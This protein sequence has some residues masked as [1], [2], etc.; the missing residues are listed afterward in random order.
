MQVHPTATSVGLA[1]AAAVMLSVGLLQQNPPIVGWGCAMMIGI[2]LARAAT[3]VSVSR[4]RAA[5]LELVWKEP[6]KVLRLTRGQRE[7]LT[8]E[9]RN[10]D[11]RAT[12]FVGLRCVA[13]DGLLI[14]TSP[15]QGQVPA[16][17]RLTVH[18]EVLAARVG[19]HAVQTLSFEVSAGTRLFEVP[20]TFASPI[21]VEVLPSPNPQQL[22]PPRGAFVRDGGPTTTRR[23]G[24]GTELRELRQYLPGD[25]LKHVAWKSSA[26]RG[27]LMVR[28]YEQ[29][30]LDRILLVLD[31][32]VELWAGTVGSAPLDRAIDA[33]A[34]VAL[35]HLS[36]G[37]EVG[38]AIVGPVRPARVRPA[39]GAAQAKQLLETLA[40]HSGCFDEPRSTF[41]LEELV[42]RVADHLRLVDSALG[43]RLT[44]PGP[45]ELA[46]LAAAAL[47][48]APISVPTPWAPT[49]AE[50]VLRRYA[51]AF[52]LGSPPRAEGDRVNTDRQL[53]E[54]LE[55]SCHG[56]GKPSLVYVWS[57]AP[58]P[59][60][61]PELER[62]LR[63]WPRRG[64]ALTWM[65]L[66][67]RPEAIPGGPE[68]A[69]VETAVSARVAIREAQAQRHLRELGV[70]VHQRKSLG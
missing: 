30:R 2:G 40:H 14:E 18:V 58:S 8:A 48:R 53:V 44:S 39:T 54:V 12:L 51:A 5:G 50:A 33:V 59:G 7:R 52:G 35:R 55:G 23:I 66:T 29:H 49:S 1:A 6:P 17:G 4:I 41:E 25:S 70:P 31:A 11:S 28:E 56:R 19:C 32:S 36:L 57:P 38:L 67:E 42:R 64:P 62:A 61:R 24:D 45:D 46:V 13:S 3:L 16:G 63:A 69:A 43:H 65:G 47:E 21:A 26:R 34:G 27:Q 22:R 9:I 37:D 20:L 68:A 60:A 15:Q 10:R